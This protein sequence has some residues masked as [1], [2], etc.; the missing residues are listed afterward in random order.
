[1]KKLSLT[2]DDGPGPYTPAILDVLAKHDV[3]ATFFMIGNRMTRERDL[4]NRVQRNG[5]MI[6]N[7]S[8]SHDDLRGASIDKL[9][10]EVLSVSNYFRPPCGLYDGFLVGFMKDRAIQMVL[11]DVDSFDWTLQTAE[12][13]CA[14]VDYQVGDGGIILLHDGDSRDASADMSRT[15]EATDRII[16]RY[17]SEGFE[18]VPLDQMTLPGTLRRTSL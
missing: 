1:M 11:W 5:H 4:V 18:F 10:D 17:K 6:G 16:T 13:I 3:R 9:R 12:E 7:H 15:V 2:F 14:M 8:W